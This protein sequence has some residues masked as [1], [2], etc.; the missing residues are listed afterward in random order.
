MSSSGGT[1]LV[2]DNAD[3]TYGFGSFA[4]GGGAAGIDILNG[5]AGG[6]VFGDIDIVGVGANQTG[7]DLRGATG[8]VTFATLD[9]TGASASGSRGIDLR[10]STTAAAIVTSESGTISGV[11][12]G[13]DLSNAAITG[14]FRYGDGSNSDADGAAS[15]IDATTPIVIAGLNAASGSYNFAD[16]VLTGDVSA[17]ATD[18]TTFWVREGASGAGTRADPGSL[19]GAEASGAGAIILLDDLSGGQDVLDAA[20][21]GGSLDLAVGQQLLSFLN[22]DTITLGGGAPANVILFG[23]A[24]GIVTN[25]FAGSGAPILTTSA[26][27]GAASV[28]L[29]GGNR[30][31]GLVI[32]NGGTGAG[33]FGDGAG[34]LIEI[35]GSRISG[36]GGA[37]SITDGAANAVLALRDL[38]LGSGATTV[39]LLGTGAGTLRIAAF[40]NLAIESAGAGAINLNDVTFDADGLGGTV[41]GG[42]LTIGA[43]GTPVTGNGLFGIAAIDGA[44]SFSAVSISSTG[45]ALTLQ[46]GTLDLTLG[47]LAVDGATTG[48]RTTGTYGGNITVT[49]NATFANTSS[50]AIIL[51]AGTGGTVDLQGTTTVTGSNVR[52]AGFAGAVLFSD[53]DIDGQGSVGTGLTVLNTTG[54]FTLAGGTITAVTGDGINIENASATI[55]NVTVTGGAGGE[56]IDFDAGA[57]NVT[58]A[59]SNATLA[60]AGG[61]VVDIARAAGSG[62]VTITALAGNTVLGGNGETGGIVIAGADGATEILF[63]ATPGGAVNPVAGGNTTIGILANPVTG[64]GLSLVNV[65]GQLDFGIL[66]IATSGGAG[67]N[68]NNSQLKTVQPA[69]SLTLTTTGGT[70]NAVAAPALVLDP[71][72]TDLNFSTVT[73]TNSTGAGIIIDGVTGTGNA[74]NALNINNLNI[75]N[76]GTAGIAAMG[77]NS[78]S[79]TFGTVQISLATA[80]ST[81]VDL[82]GAVLNGDFTASA[83]DLSSS[84]ATGTIGIDLRG[85]TG[86]GT[87][88]FGDTTPPFG[89]GTAPAIAGVLT[90]VILNDASNLNF[91]FGDGEG[92]TDTGSS[93][94]AVTAIDFTDATGANGTFNFLDVTFPTAGSTANLESSLSVYWVDED[95]DGNG[96]RGDPGSLGGA[97]AG[98][99]DVIVFVNRAD[100]GNG[101]PADIIDLNLASQGSI[102]SYMPAD[103]QVLVSFRTGDSIDLAAF[104]LSAGGPPANLLLTGIPVGSTVITNPGPAGSGAPVLTTSL[105]ATDT[106]ILGAGRTNVFSGLSI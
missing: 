23:I 104:G 92:A 4:L 51:I 54:P 69:L 7:V 18:V 48:L 68:V 56:A 11:G 49:G 34:G 27:G 57:S 66:D 81:G 24:P 44:L 98:T 88:L 17:L 61:N 30:L 37:I 101:D 22:G 73:S 59:L 80:N 32:A 10:G 26:G 13:V 63:D 19:A 36:N 43:A 87:I 71:L 95:A 29:A 40:S 8:A 31:D 12:I 47:S 35:A 103:G 2:F 86:T 50:E 85:A 78:G 53:L 20:G 65:A 14:S 25:P 3:G 6:F 55:S 89:G 70:I 83:F 105:A 28:I 60:S 62:T 38:T 76:P 52:I 15:A 99:A 94:A 102:G 45:R 67:L 9:I 42:M 100:S 58:F 74:N 1:G 96:S 93:I 5:S 64:A 91:T 84:T 82:S 16:V 72:N 79:I 106:I 39:S 46:G 77:V 75:S 21:A 90:G 41:D 97:A 33:V